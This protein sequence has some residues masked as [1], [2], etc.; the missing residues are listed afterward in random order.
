MKAVVGV[1][2]LFVVAC[3]GSP[4]SVVEEDE[5][6]SDATAGSEAPVNSEASPSDSSGIEERTITAAT[7]Q[8]IT[9]TDQLIS[10]ARFLPVEE[11]NVMIGIRL[12]GIQSESVLSKLGFENGDVVLS[13]AGHSLASAPETLEALA[14]VRAQTEFDVVI[15]R[16]ER[17]FA[18]HFRLECEGAAECFDARGSEPVDADSTAVDSAAVE[19]H[20]I[21]A[22]MM[23]VLSDS[24]QRMV[25]ARLMPIEEANVITGVR[26]GGIRRQS[27]L[28]TLGLAS[29]DVVLSMGGRTPAV[30]VA[31]GLASFQG[32][33]GV[34]VVI[35]RGER[36]F[37]I[38]YHYE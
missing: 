7:M 22:A 31:G 24:E 20:T 2:T 28:S 3:G 29:G 15:R 19:Q 16:E 33:A 5:V 34:D 9:D 12:F 6:S 38:H 23:Q 25:L 21:T 11:A 8:V 4:T 37:T 1:V 17:T 13:L 35:R 27:L 30:D 32:P 26:L 36:T 18:V 14:A 10:L